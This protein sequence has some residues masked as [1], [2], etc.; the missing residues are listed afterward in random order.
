MAPNKF[1]KHIKE[2]LEEREILPSSKAWEQLSEKMD[3]ASPQSSKKGYLWYGIAASFIGLIMLSVVF[4]TTE[5]TI[6][7]TETIVV[8]EQKE[9]IEETNN[10]QNVEILETEDEVVSINKI[11]Q[12]K[13]KKIEVQPYIEVYKKESLEE[14][15][16]AVESNPKETFTDDSEKIINTKVLEVIAQIN[17]LEQNE[18]SLSDA[19][20]DSLL[21][22]AQEDILK[23]KLFNIDNSVN[24]MALLTEVEDELNQSFRDQIFE[25]L[26]TKFQKVRT[27]VAVRNN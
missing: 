8:E 10:F 24:A 11:P 5:S 27:A 22:K 25:S 15:L 6:L 17:I 16:I 9:V 2:K 14:Q 1:E 4:F 20:V 13:A 23:E 21:R 18:Q 12:E 3:T 26:K 7:E 19:E